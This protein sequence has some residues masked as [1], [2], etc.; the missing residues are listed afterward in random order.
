MPCEVIHDAQGN[1]WILCS[2]KRRQQCK[3]C[4]RGYVSKLCDFPV[5][6]GKTCDAGMC[7]DCATR[8]GHEVDYCPNHRGQTPPQQNLFGE[9][10]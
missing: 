5:A 6:T 10:S 3:F 7:D 8:I 9:Q 1:V 4:R 2:R